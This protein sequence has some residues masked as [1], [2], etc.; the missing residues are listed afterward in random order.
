VQG[1]NETPYNYPNDPI[2]SSDISGKSKENENNIVV[3][4]AWI[5]LALT[6]G[7]CARSPKTCLDIRITIAARSGAATAFFIAKERGYSPQRT[8][9]L[10]GDYTMIGLISGLVGSS[11]FTYFR[12][13]GY[14]TSSAGTYWL[15]QANK[16]LDSLAYSGTAALTGFFLKFI[17]N[18]TPSLRGKK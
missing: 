5:S 8:T 4:M 11:S 6:A 14:Y 10:L 13:G 2:N 16:A 9:K 1:G 7:L 12:L 15:Q 18:Q 3:T 17:Y